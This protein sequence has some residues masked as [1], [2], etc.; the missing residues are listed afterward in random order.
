M[1]FGVEYTLR[2][3]ELRGGV[4]SSRAVALGVVVYAVLAQVFA[5]A[6]AYSCLG[7]VIYLVWAL[8]LGLIKGHHFSRQRPFLLHSQELI[9]HLNPNV[10]SALQGEG[11]VLISHHRLLDRRHST[12]ED[13]SSRLNVHHRQQSPPIRIQ[14]SPPNNLPSVLTSVSVSVSVC[15]CGC[16]SNFSPRSSNLTPEKNDISSSPVQCI[17][18]AGAQPKRTASGLDPTSS[19]KLGWTVKPQDPGL[20]PASALCVQELE[21]ASSR[22]MPCSCHDRRAHTIEDSKE[23]AS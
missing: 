1:A 16:G 17:G 11:G 9:S 4:E 8:L 19:Q 12:L 5:N 7:C 14:P 23:D 15:G 18:W 3:P 6:H 13:P 21:T 10:D 22:T 20:P 2:C